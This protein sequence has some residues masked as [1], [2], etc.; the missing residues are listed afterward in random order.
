MELN[1]KSK[2]SCAIFGTGGFGKKL[3]HKLAI[4][5]NIRAFSS[6]DR[7]QWNQT[8]YDIPI[9]PP[10]DLLNLSDTEIIIASTYF[11]E[12]KNQLH[13][14]GLTSVSYLDPDSKLL[15]KSV[16]PIQKSIKKILFV[17][18]NPCIRT[19]KLSCLLKSNGIRVDLAFLETHPQITFTNMELPWDNVIPI[20][21]LNDFYT[22]INE[23]DY[24]L[25][26]HSNE[27]DALT[28]I[29][30]HTNKKVVHD[31]HDMMSLRSDISLNGVVHEYLANKF[32]NGCMYTSEE[33]KQLA[34]QKFRISG[35]DILVLE[36]LIYEG[37]KP[38]KTLPK[39]SASDGKFHC[40]YEGGILS[41]PDSHRYYEDMFLKLAQNG[42]HV[43][44][45]SPFLDPY[46]DTLSNKSEYL[47]YEGKKGVKELLDVMTRYDIGLMLLNVTERNSLFLQT[48]SPNKLYDYLTAG[49]P[50]LV[51]NVNSLVN[52]IDKYK[53]GACIDWNNNVLKQ[54][55]ET[56]QIK[57]DNNFLSD[58]QLSMD[59]K[60]NEILDFY[61]KVAFS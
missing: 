53:V 5:Y 59:S 41:D 6:N 49:L 3:Y 2:K 33:V 17:Q 7:V 21:N 58:H 9:I 26:H 34:I 28:S 16:S 60:I 22:F 23:S 19:F 52:F 43:H 24:D 29:L 61:N 12:I 4:S 31:T 15:I 48:A 44:F 1:M 39:L 8:I 50:V 54:V 30:L 18:R 25:I 38:K 32:S 14:M 56:A 42:I 27:P 57:I 13:S 47:H 37:L 10:H 11:E 55:E 45:Y 51:S 36:N 20:H 46:Y 40:V 35:K